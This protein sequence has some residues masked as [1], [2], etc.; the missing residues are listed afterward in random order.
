MGF[1]ARGAALN[2]EPT[3]PTLYD[4]I[5]VGNQ[6]RLLGERPLTTMPVRLGAQTGKN[7]NGM[8]GPDPDYGRSRLQSTSLQTRYGRSQPCT[9][10]AI[11]DMKLRQTLVPHSANSTASEVSNSNV[12]RTVA[13]CN[14]PLRV[15]RS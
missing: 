1:L 12:P 13:G 15:V 2:R 9:Q 5:K 6:T 3:H 8:S 14:R 11:E 10:W 7:Q 4:R